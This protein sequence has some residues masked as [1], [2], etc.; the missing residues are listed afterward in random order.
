MPTSVKDAGTYKNVGAL[1]YKDAGTWKPVQRAYIKV[2]GAWVESFAAAVVVNITASTTALNLQSLFSAPDWA[3]TYKKKIVNIAS[4]V[5]VGSTN[6]GVAAV[7]TGTAMGGSLELNIAGEVQGAGGAAGTTGA[8]GN[9]GP[10]INNQLSAGQLTVTVAATGAVRG[11]G[12]GGGKG[13]TGGA[14]SNVVRTPSSGDYYDLAVVG[15]AWSV[16]SGSASYIYWGSTSNHITT[17]STGA[18]SVVYGGY[19]YYRGSYQG[20]T[21]WGS[22]LWGIYRT[23]GGATTGGAGGNGGLG[24][25][26]GQVRSNG[27]AGAAG[28]TNAGAGGTGGNGGDW[29]AGGTAGTTGN[30]GNNGAG[31]A[32]AVS[33]APGAAITGNAR[34]VVNN[35]TI[36]GSY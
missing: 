24:R 29:G 7:I 12:G 31:V 32:G 13:G 8:G 2:E 33:G 28:G 27:S 9:G 36:N 20:D 15:Y 35:G 21:E 17:T 22:S 3:A 23:S 16:V 1:W 4:G 26:Y 14:G 34:T 25:G 6:V 30:A 19:T 18:T 11:G 5:I 10:A